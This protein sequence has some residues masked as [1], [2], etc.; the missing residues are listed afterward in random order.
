MVSRLLL[1]GAGGEKRVVRCEKGDCLILSLRG[2]GKSAPGQA[3]LSSWVTR[4]AG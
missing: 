3:C 2:A 1:L 4:G